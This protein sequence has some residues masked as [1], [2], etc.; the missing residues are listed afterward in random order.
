MVLAGKKDPF[1]VRAGPL[2]WHS[3][4]AGAAHPPRARYGRFR[5]KTSTPTRSAGGRRL[6]PPARTKPACSTVCTAYPY[7]LL[8]VPRV[9][10]RRTTPGGRGVSR[11]L[12]LPCGP[13]PHPGLPAPLRLA[14]LEDLPLGPNRSP[15]RSRRLSLAAVDISGMSGFPAGRVSCSRGAAH[16]AG[17]DPRDTGRRPGDLTRWPSCGSRRFRRRRWR[18][19]RPVPVGSARSGTGLNSRAYRRCA[20]QRVLVSK[21]KPPRGGCPVARETRHVPVLHAACAVAAIGG[22]C[23]CRRCRPY[24]QRVCFSGP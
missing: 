15:A 13:V 7:A 4:P 22:N 17:P 23:G 6:T 24:R 8:C 19:R 3:V 9:S 2:P 18:R 10:A 14:D 16:K 12:P 21:A 20:E 1:S 5:P 11:V